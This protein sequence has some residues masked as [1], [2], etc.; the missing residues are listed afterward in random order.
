MP[1]IWP[2]P[3][4]IR[5]QLREIKQDHHAHLAL[6]SIWALCSDGAGVRDN[7]II[8]TQTKKCTKTEK[9]SSGHDFKIVVMMESWSKLTDSQRHVALDEALC[10]CGV[11]YVPQSMEINGKKEIVK[12]DMGRTIYTEEMEYD[13]EGN[14]KWKINPPDADLFLTLLHRHGQYNEQAENVLRVANGQPPRRPLAAERA[15]A[16]GEPDADE[17]EIPV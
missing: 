14:P 11:K 15:D 16:A 5:K 3:E 13:Q 7:R 10:R 4:G 12:D 2:A 1:S 9:L 6:A 8:V 17:V